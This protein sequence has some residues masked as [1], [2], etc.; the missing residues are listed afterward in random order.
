M[1]ATFRWLLVACLV[2]SLPLKGLAAA[3][4]WGCGLQHAPVDGMVTG[5]ATGPVH[6][7]FHGEPAEHPS[8]GLLTADDAGG[9][10]TS[11]TGSTC[12]QCEPC[13]GAAVLPVDWALPLSGAGPAA[14]KVAV[15]PLTVGGR[16]G[17]LDRPPR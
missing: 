3:G 9:E 6:A 15:R 4:H 11:V 1:H 17:R 16:V 14:P 2:L 12:A 13:C 5:L 8:P 7:H 10:S